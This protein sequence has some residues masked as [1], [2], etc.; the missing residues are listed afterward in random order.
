MRP[1]GPPRA[2]G[3][4]AAQPRSHR[5]AAA[6][7]G[8]RSCAPG[9]GSCSCAP[10][11][12]VARSRSSASAAPTTTRSTPSSGSPGS[13]TPTRPYDAASFQNA[14]SAID[15]TFNW[16][17]ADSRDISY[18]SSGLLPVRAAADADFD[19]PRWGDKPLR[20][21][22]L[23]AQRRPRARR[24][25][26]RRGY[27]VE[28]EQQAG[29]RLR[30][31][32]T[33]SGA[34]ARSTAASR[35]RTAIDGRHQRRRQGVP[36]PAGRPRGRR[37]DSRLAGRATRF[38]CCSTSSATTPK[39]RRSGTACAPGCTTARTA[40][41]VTATVP[42][43]T[44]PRS[45]LFDEWWESQTTEQPGEESVA[46]DVLPG[47]S[48]RSPTTCPGA[49][50]PPAPRPGLGVE[51]RRLVRLRRQ[52]PTP[53][54]RP[55]RSRRP[56]RAPTAAPARWPRAGPTCALAR[57]RGRAGARRPGHDV[58]LEP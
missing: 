49:R 45:P 24:P 29:A 31:R 11:S 32:R 39:P 23:A 18:Y 53:G 21:A 30:R 14:V 17:Y 52:G 38:R 2:R 26:R 20:L 15:Y 40:S 25:T 37:G 8:S 48:A 36:G 58:G 9:T 6:S 28:L 13:T 44:R 16:F 54:A 12:A 22:G 34:T 41:T 1:D 43:R 47:D 33:T 7:C 5:A 35:S 42:M 56:T 57:A 10:P 3:D 27:L 46:K 4:R 51:R 55:V 50:R 19:L